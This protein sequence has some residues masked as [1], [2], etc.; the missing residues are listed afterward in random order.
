ML[1]GEAKR[2]YQ[3]AYMQKR[4]LNAKNGDNVIL[5]QKQPKKNAP[6][7]ITI[8]ERPAVRPVRPQDVRPMLDPDIVRPNMLDLVRH[9]NTC[10]LLTNK[11][12]LCCPIGKSATYSTASFSL[13]YNPNQD[14]TQHLRKKQ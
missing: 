14:C 9:C 11:G 5:A 8:N 1:V 10:S 3:R 12:G 2:E 6:E 7:S 4:R 13:Q